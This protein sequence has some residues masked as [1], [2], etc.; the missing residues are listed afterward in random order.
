MKRLFFK[1]FHLNLQTRLFSDKKQPEVQNRKTTYK[2]FQVNHCVRH[3]MFPLQKSS[4]AFIKNIY[5]PNPAQI[6]RSFSIV[7]VKNHQTH[8]ANMP[9]V[10]EG[11]LNI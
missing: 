7:L 6:S 3:C 9:D 2:K 1:Y 11:R 5:R 4:V 8:S 10:E